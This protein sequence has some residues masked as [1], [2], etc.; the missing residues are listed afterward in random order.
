MMDDE[1]VLWVDKA[2]ETIG[3]RQHGGSMDGM[4]ML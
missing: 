1:L 2:H 3:Q 4:R